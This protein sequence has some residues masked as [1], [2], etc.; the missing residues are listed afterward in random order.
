MGIRLPGPPTRH[1]KG[2]VPVPALGRVP[3]AVS[4]AQVPGDEAPGAAADHPRPTASVIIM[5]RVYRADLELR[6]AVG[7]GVQTPL[8]HVARQ[9]VHLERALAARRVPDHRGP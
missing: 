8:E 4:G 5:T 3:A 2:E 9:V 6:V 7:P 1:P